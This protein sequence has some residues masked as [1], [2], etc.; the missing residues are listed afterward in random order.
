MSIRYRSALRLC[1]GCVKQHP[2][3]QLHCN[4]S[5]NCLPFR[6]LPRELFVPQAQYLASAALV[7]TH[8]CL[9]FLLRLK[10]GWDLRHKRDVSSV[11]RSEAGYR[12]HQSDMRVC[13]D[14]L[15]DRYVHIL[16]P[17]ELEQHAFILPNGQVTYSFFFNP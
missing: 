6:Y 3:S 7:C 15:L 10:R 11:A 13:L 17:V 9:G 4:C 12:R 5:Y 2:L 16:V 14:C 8:H 1:Y